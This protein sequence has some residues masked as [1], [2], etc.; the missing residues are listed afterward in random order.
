VNFNA[1]FGESGRMGLSIF[2]FPF[3]VEKATNYF[4]YLI[5]IIK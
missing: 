3:Y 5:S 2:S 1:S 4:N